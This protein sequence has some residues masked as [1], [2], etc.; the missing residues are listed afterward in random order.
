MHVKQTSMIALQKL[1]AKV[2]GEEA[3]KLEGVGGRVAQQQRM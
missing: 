2:K 1:T 3:C